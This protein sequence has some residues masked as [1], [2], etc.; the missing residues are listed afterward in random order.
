MVGKVKG[1]GK[2]VGGQRERQVGSAFEHLR[3]LQQALR[4]L[5]WKLWLCRHRQRNHEF[6]GDTSVTQSIVIMLT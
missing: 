5:H 6:V 3:Q 2:L 4:R 1:S